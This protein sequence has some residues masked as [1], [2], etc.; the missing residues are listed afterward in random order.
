MPGA[1][2]RQ[3]RKERGAEQAEVRRTQVEQEGHA[4]RGREAARR[5]RELTE[6]NHKL[7]RANADLSAEATAIRIRAPL[8]PYTPS[9]PAPSYDP[10]P[11]G[12]GAWAGF[13]SPGAGGWRGAG[14]H[15]SKAWT[16]TD[17]LLARAAG[18]VGA[19]SRASPQGGDGGGGHDALMGLMHRLSEARERAG[20][21]GVGRGEV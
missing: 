7:T 13:A 18:A 19:A 6:E 5:V 16:P 1:C 14:E 12:G 20:G 21:G 4:V 11:A 9:A 3:A 8:A 2:I 17:R 10:P 15:G